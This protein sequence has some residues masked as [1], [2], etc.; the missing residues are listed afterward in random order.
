[1]KAHGT[2]DPELWL[3][4]SVPHHALVEMAAYLGMAGVVLD[5]EKVHVGPT[6]MQAMLLA[7][8]KHG[9]AAKVRLRES[10]PERI[11]YI[12]SLGAETILLPRLTS[13]DSVTTAVASTLFPNRGTRGLGHSRATG[14]GLRQSWAELLD[15]SA[16]APQVEIIVETQEMVNNVE[17]VTRLDSVHGLDIGLLDMSAALGR[18]GDG[19]APEVQQAIDRIISAAR[20]AGKP[21]GMSVGTPDGAAEMWRRGLTSVVLDAGMLLKLG[22]TEFRRALTNAQQLT[23]EE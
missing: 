16:P 1:M 6:G 22:L 3:F 14:Y 5:D 11:E 17:R 4:A 9:L 13:V 19:A 10:S 15:G 8:E 7:A 18:P 20:A 23:S 21:V 2:G 12:L